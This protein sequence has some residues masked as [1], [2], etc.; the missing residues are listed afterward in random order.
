MS[1]RGLLM[2]SLVTLASC[3]PNTVQNS[4]VVAPPVGD[5]EA[6]VFLIGDT[7]NPHRGFEP[8]LAALGRDLSRSVDSTVVVFLGDNLYPR[9]LPAADHSGR[10]EGERRLDDQMAVLAAHGV[11][12]IFIPG[13]HDWDHSGDS[14]W[15]SVKRQ[16]RYVEAESNALARVMP[17]DGCPGPAV[18][19]LANT[20]RVIA[21]DSQWWLH[22]G[23]KPTTQSSGCATYTDQMMLDSLG[24][25]LRGAGPREVIIAA[26]HPLRSGG[27]HGGSF[28]WKAHLFPLR[29]AHDWL[30]IP[31][32]ILGSLYPI[33]RS[34]GIYLQDLNSGPYRRF[35]GAVDSVLAEYYP[36]AYAAGHDHNLQVTQS[37]SVQFLLVSG[38]GIFGHTDP[39]FMIE[40]SVFA[41]AEPGYM[42]VDAMQDGRV[43]LAVITVEE[44]GVGRE[45][46]SQWLK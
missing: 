33:A 40:G 13:N 26:H 4:H 45:A 44:T 36:L 24:G 39:A 18:L 16:G 42:R 23:P 31:L 41:R 32:P 25:A 29:D 2:V 37:E 12:G 11:R 38:S 35:R 17:R 46:Y 10:S 43:R 9:G 1:R 6:T 34:A 5:I 7:G 21:I 28:G 30:W 3:G 27:R 22:P 14:G 8:V 15:V 19:D 20:L